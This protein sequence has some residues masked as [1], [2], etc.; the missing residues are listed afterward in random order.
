[1]RLDESDLADL[2]ARQLRDYDA[3][4]P[5]TLFAEG[6]S[7]S[8]GQAY[9]IQ[10]EVCRLREQ[11]GETVIGYKIGCTS[12]VIQQQL[13]IDHPVF[14]RLFATERHES[15]VELPLKRFFNLAIEGE[16]AVRLSKSVPSGHANRDQILRSVG[17]LFPVIELHN[18]VLRSP[19][20]AAAELIA[21]NAL[22]AGF[23]APRDE[24]GLP[25]S[26][27]LP[28]RISLNGEAIAEVKYS[29]WQDAVVNA[30]TEL[31]SL[32]PSHGLSLKAGHVLLTGSLA[33]LIPASSGTSVEVTT[34][35]L[36]SV[37]ATFAV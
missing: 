2:A 4:T 30:I 14:G 33:E 24:P 21:N 20:Q 19:D 35:N 29:R 16:L 1:V 32:L 12:P 28:L 37:A 6:G 13:G 17:S 8:E 9:A 25:S 27:E 22:H 23:V 15:G 3:H 36:G 5:G 10:S 7:L 18:H 34:S 31:G 26:D 11:R